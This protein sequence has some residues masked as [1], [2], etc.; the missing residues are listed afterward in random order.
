MMLPLRSMFPVARGGE[1]PVVEIESA[2]VIEMA[3]EPYLELFT[4]A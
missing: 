4:L 1:I 2:V 3:M